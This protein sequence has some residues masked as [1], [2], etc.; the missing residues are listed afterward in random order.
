MKRML[1]EISRIKK[2][3]T[4]KIMTNNSAIEFSCRYIF[5]SF[6]S[7]IAKRKLMLNT[8]Y[9]IINSYENT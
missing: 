3:D 4:N 7:K 9:Q 8:T 2:S 1:S 6:L 5:Q